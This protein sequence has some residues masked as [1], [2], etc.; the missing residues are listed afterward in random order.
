VTK[1]IQG[2][3]GVPNF[4]LPIS[5]ENGCWTVKKLLRWFAIGALVL[6]LAVLFATGL[7]VDD[8]SRDLTTNR[9]E[10]SQDNR[11]PM[12]R[13]LAV[14]ATLNEIQ[15]AVDEFSRERV[16][17]KITSTQEVGDTLQIA[18][19]R[20]TRWL[21]FVDDVSIA[22]SPVDAGVRIDIVS[23]SRV[24]K[25]DLGQNPRNIRELAGWLRV[26]FR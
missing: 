16:N 18:M 23:Q 7:Q 9:S 21:R 8:W 26:R 25:G 11:D 5:R 6:L 10:T 24:G 19:E 2:A 3:K 22:S 20:T 1:G 15:L 12:L 14:S 13:P 17:W 4:E